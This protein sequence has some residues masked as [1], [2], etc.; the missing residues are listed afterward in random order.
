[1]RECYR[2]ERYLTAYADGELKPR[3]NR[4][5]ES[6]LAACESCRRELDSIVASDRILRSAGVPSVPTG[7][8]TLFGRELSR[9]LDRVDA[10]SRRPTRIREMRPVY[11]YR[12]RA[13]AVVAASAAVVVAIL[14]LGPAAV[15]PWRA[16]G[17]GNECIVE[18][19][20]TYAAGYTPMF[21]SSDDPEM[22]VI[23]VF[24]EEV[25]ASTNGEPLS[26]P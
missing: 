6:H 16:G 19:I 4:R 9:A 25:E 18:S 2:I 21:F 8:W 3:L 10:E 26:A 20:E 5:V 15:V 23:W 24:S 17:G 14:A 13:F 22:T 12:R 7:R 1:M 11:G